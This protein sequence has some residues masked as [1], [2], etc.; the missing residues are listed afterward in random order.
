MTLWDTL[1][2]CSRRTRVRRDRARIANPPYHQ[3]Y[4][5][6]RSTGVFPCS[7]VSYELGCG[8]RPRYGY[9]AQVY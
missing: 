1:N 3:L 2:A 4:F 6:S 7:A 8:G 5:R 9:R